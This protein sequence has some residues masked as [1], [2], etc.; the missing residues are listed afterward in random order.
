M[1]KK[2][3]DVLIVR[4]DKQLKVK[5]RKISDLSNRKMSDYI[6]LLIQYAADAEIKL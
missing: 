2:Q 6:R 3:P 4:L 1:K 5:L